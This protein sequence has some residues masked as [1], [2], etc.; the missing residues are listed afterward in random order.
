MLAMPHPPGQYTCP[1][2]DSMPHKCIRGSP[3]LA[4]APVQVVREVLVEKERILNRR[5]TNA[6]K[7]RELAEEW[8]DCD[9]DDA[10]EAGVS[11]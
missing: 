7:S 8:H 11:F 3:Q 5:L 9:E 1:Q 4:C 10:T 2:N 6:R